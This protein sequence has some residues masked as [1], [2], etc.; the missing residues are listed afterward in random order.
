[1]AGIIKPFIDRGDVLNKED[2]NDIIKELEKSSSNKDANNLRNK[3]N[4]KINKLSVTENPTNTKSQSLSLNDL[5]VGDNVFVKKLNQEGSILSISKDG[6]IQVSLGLGKMFFD[7]SDL[8][9]SKTSPSK[10]N[11]KKD[12]SSRK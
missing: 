10:Q 2:A 4:T 11:T 9:L 6:K 12:Y 1:M 8:E 5:K 7:I 3:L